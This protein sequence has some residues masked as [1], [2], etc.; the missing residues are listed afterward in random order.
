MKVI[1]DVNEDI[2]YKKKEEIIKFLLSV[3]DE[4]N[5][6]SFFYLFMMLESGKFLYDEAL[7]ICN[8]SAILSKFDVLRN[9]KDMYKIFA[10]MLEKY[11]LLNGN[12]CEVAA[13]CYPRL[14]EIIYPTIEKKKFSL[15]IYDPKLVIQKLGNAKLYRG[16]LV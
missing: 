12:C 7:L 6:K 9:E 15:S 13:G 5:P 4:Y 3:K 14:S 1:D 10:Q 16:N 11:S 8:F 2:Y